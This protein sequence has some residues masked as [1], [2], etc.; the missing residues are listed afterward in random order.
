MRTLPSQITTA[1]QGQEI[2]PVRLVDVQIGDTTYY[3]SDHYRNLTAN[4][5]LYLPNGRLLNIDNVAN[6]TT[7]DEDSIEIS[8]SAI[9]SI[10]RTDVLAADV[11][12]GEV[13]I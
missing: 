8:L 9:E 12:G 11:I 13:T 4:T 3:I 1:I 10:F 2:W 5:N 7:A 6:K